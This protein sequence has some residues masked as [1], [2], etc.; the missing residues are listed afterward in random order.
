MTISYDFIITSSWNWGGF[1]QI[2][3]RNHWFLI[4]DWVCSVAGSHSA[5]NRHCK[6]SVLCRMITVPTSTT[7][8]ALG[9]PPWLDFW[10]ISNGISDW[11]WTLSIP[12]RTSQR[13]CCT[14]GELQFWPFPV[15]LN[16]CE[17]ESLDL[18]ELT[19]PMELNLP[20]ARRRQLRQAISRLPTLSLLDRWILMNPFRSVGEIAIWMVVRMCAK[21]IPSKR[22][23]LFMHLVNIQKTKE[24]HHVL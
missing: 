18:H 1:H 6:L 3:R 2:S 14:W 4:L 7:E 10:M 19:V 16:E 22:W 8:Y 24:N 5:M 20:C 9:K 12:K 15:R 11:Q 23:R 13:A 21:N 17:D